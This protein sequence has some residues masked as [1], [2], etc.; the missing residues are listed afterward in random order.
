MDNEHASIAVNF[1]V[2]V[3][4][5]YPRN[6]RLSQRASLLLDLAHHKRI[7]LPLDIL[8]YLVERALF[9]SVVMD[10]RMAF[11]GAG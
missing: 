9:L 10:D 2:M 6:C 8:G 3:R 1:G 7:G 4:H 11:V 5:R